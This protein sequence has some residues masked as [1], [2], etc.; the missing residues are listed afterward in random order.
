MFI[1]ININVTHHPTT[2]TTRRYSSGLVLEGSCLVSLGCGLQIW[3]EI[4]LWSVHSIC[5]KY[6]LGQIVTLCLGGQDFL[7]RGGMYSVQ[8]SVRTLCPQRGP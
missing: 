5:R 4:F 1:V 3:V 6:L 7:V 2:A 8:V